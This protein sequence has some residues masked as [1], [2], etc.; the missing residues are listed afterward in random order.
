MSRIITLAVNNKSQD[1]EALL[2]IGKKIDIEINLTKANDIYQHFTITGKTEDFKRLIEAYPYEIITTYHAEL[3]NV[4]DCDDD[5]L[6]TFEEVLELIN[7]AKN[8]TSRANTAFHNFIMPIKNIEVLDILEKYS[9]HMNETQRN[10]IRTRQD[11]LSGNRSRFEEE[12]TEYIRSTSCDV[13][14]LRERTGMSR[15]DFCKHFDIPYRTVEDW[16]NKKSTCSSYLYKL[17]VKDL[18]S[19]G[20]ISLE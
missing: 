5:W 1:V 16:E 4:A 2:D 3:G 11:V 17:M 7:T 8:A 18:T 9:C 6:K 15:A 13:K 14:A 20:I 19:S 12:M 10:S